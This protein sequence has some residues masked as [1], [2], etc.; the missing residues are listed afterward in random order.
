MT[1]YFDATRHE[2]TA[3]EIAKATFVFS[4]WTRIEQLPNYRGKLHTTFVWGLPFLF[5]TR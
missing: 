5:L 2:Y 4:L 1:V 3:E